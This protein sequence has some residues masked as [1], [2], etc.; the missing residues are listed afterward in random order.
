MDAKKIFNLLNS[1]LWQDFNGFLRN[2]L[3]NKDYRRPF[4]L[5]D[6]FLTLIY[7]AASPIILFKFRKLINIT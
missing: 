2:E 1:S 3:P 6:I 4:I 5:T 7:A